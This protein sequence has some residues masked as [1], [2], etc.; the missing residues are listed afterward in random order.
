[1][2]LHELE[3]K[4]IDIQSEK[5]KIEAEMRRLYELWDEQR[6]IR[7]ELKKQLIQLKDEKND[8]YFLTSCNKLK[9]G[10]WFTV[11][12]HH[13]STQRYN[14]TH[15]AEAIEKDT[16]VIVVK[17][18]MKTIRVKFTK[19]DGKQYEKTISKKAFSKFIKLSDQSQKYV[20]DVK[21]KNVL[22]DV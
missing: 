3:H 22:S 6:N 19:L 5:Q 11:K 13:E 14:V 18:N 1:M 20:R 12:K 9:E 16:K 2:N 8:A 10:D 21:L 4:I 17:V 7:K 15:L